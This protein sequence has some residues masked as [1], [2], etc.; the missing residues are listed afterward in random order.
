MIWT[1]IFGV[2]FAFFKIQNAVMKGG[3][4]SDEEEE[5]A[6]MDLPEM[7]VLAYPEFAGT[8]CTSRTSRLRSELGTRP[9]RTSPS[10]STQP[11]GTGAASH[12]RR[13]ESRRPSIGIVADLVSEQTAPMDF[14]E[15][16]LDILVVLVAAK[17]AA[18]VSERIGIP[19][20]VGEIV[21]GILVG[22]SV[23]G[24][25]GRATTSCARSASS[26]SM[27]L[28]LEVG[29]GDGPRRARQ[30]RAGLAQ[31]AI[32]GVVAP[33]RPRARGHASARRRASTRRS[34]SAPRYRDE[35]RHHRPRLR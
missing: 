32:I 14:A 1:V 13:D 18:E 33:A 11:V 3:I 2:A 28:L 9:E 26:A 8:T 5:L 20:V 19:A 22:P 7:G 15:L 23:L 16:L 25:V 34:S 30:G 29:H 10:P 17:V 6:G 31:V 27:L 4:R 21:A 35:R 12:R 24:L